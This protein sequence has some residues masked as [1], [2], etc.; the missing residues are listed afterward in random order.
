MTLGD[1]IVRLTQTDVIDSRVRLPHTKRI[2]RRCLPSLREV[3]DGTAAAEAGRMALPGCF[4]HH[5]I[6]A[7][8]S[9]GLMTDMLRWA[10]GISGIDRESKDD[11]A[12]I[13]AAMAGFIHRAEIDEAMVALAARLGPEGIAQFQEKLAEMDTAMGEVVLQG[14]E[15]T[16]RIMARGAL[17]ILAGVDSGQSAGIIGALTVPVLI[18]EG[19]VAEWHDVVVDGR[20]RV[21]H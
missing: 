17:V 4:G 15:R 3:V 5:V 11:R 18:R 16:D 14:R 21:L 20:H 19:P 9:R 10:G 1:H 7:C 6:F 12:A 13:W 8:P 2:L